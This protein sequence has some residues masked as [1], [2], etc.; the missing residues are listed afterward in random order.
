MDHQHDT[1]DGSAAGDQTPVGD[2]CG[3]TFDR[4]RCGLPAGHVG[5]HRAD[6]GAQRAEWNERATGRRLRDLARPR[7][8]S[9]DGQGLSDPE[10]S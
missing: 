6:D 10:G 1:A 9:R 7:H 4:W 2:R 5:P 3:S 8:P